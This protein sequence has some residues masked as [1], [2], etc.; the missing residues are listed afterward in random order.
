VGNEG[1]VHEGGN[2]VGQE[3]DKSREIMKYTAQDLRHNEDV[4]EENAAVEESQQ[5]RENPDGQVKESRATSAND[6][7]DEIEDEALSTQDGVD[8]KTNAKAVN[9]SR[10]DAMA[11]STD[12]LG[13]DE[14]EAA[15][16]NEKSDGDSN[17]SSPETYID[18]GE[19]EGAGQDLQVAESNANDDVS[20]EDSTPTPDEFEHQDNKADVVVVNDPDDQTSIGTDHKESIATADGGEPTQNDSSIAA[21]RG[22]VKAAVT[23]ASDAI[24]NATSDAIKNVKDALRTTVASAK[25]GK[26]DKED[27]T[28]LN[29]GMPS[30]NSDAEGELG[31]KPQSSDTAKKQ[32]K[33]STKAIAQTDTTGTQQAEDG[34]TVMTPQDSSKPKAE[35]GSSKADDANVAKADSKPE[36]GT[37]ISKEDSKT[38]AGRDLLRRGTIM[39]AGKDGKGDIDASTGELFAKLSRRFPHASCM[40]DLDFQAFKSKTL[41]ANA[42]SG[43]LVGRRG[44]AKM[45]PIFAKITNEIKSVQ[46]THNQ[47]EQYMSALKTCYETVFFDMAK[48]LDSLQASMDQR[49]A[50]LERAVFLSEMRA[51]GNNSPSYD[52]VTK[53]FATFP[54][55]ASAFQFTA[56]PTMPEYSKVLFAGLA[57]FL[58][59]L[60]RCLPRRKKPDQNMLSSHMAKRGSHI[61]AINNSPKTADPVSSPLRHITSLSENNSRHTKKSPAIQIPE[62]TLANELLEKENLAVSNEKLSS[63]QTQHIVAAGTCIIAA[64]LFSTRM[65]CL[66]T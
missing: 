15:V 51:K 50:S 54:L 12:G 27:N 62:L 1:E 11:D 10:Q 63:L 61:E 53:L 38:T 20:D 18:L 65:N 57:I 17:E 21:V 42:G 2:S 7:E 48:D 47:Y 6:P 9:E 60:L 3:E 19:N 26:I 35:E 25:T 45:E 29:E 58:L 14:D 4:T 52:G 32:D 43:G 16:N 44:G 41:L 31:S 28:P 64:T 40:K 39:L 22:V 30:N 33:P 59:L 13:S 37:P 23:D 36:K 5:T 49:L 56:T 24:K 46:I 66:D 8:E 55:A 34:S